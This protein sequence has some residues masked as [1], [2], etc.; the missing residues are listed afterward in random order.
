VLSDAGEPA[1]LRHDPH[2]RS[3]AAMLLTLPLQVPAE[4]DLA[5]LSTDTA[6]VAVEKAAVA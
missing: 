4:W 1:T 3:Y 6:P 2:G 5:P